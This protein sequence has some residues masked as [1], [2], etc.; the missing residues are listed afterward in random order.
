MRVCVCLNFEDNDTKRQ[1]RLWNQV[2]QRELENLWNQVEKE[3]EK[4]KERGKKMREL[5]SFWNQVEVKKKKKKKSEE[6][7]ESSGSKENEK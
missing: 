6:L 7:L 2:S 5:E 1:A 4:K 3:K